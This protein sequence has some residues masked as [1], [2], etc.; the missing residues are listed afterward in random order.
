MYVSVTIYIIYHVHG[1]FQHD[2]FFTFV[3]MLMI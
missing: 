2:S 3:C 1:K